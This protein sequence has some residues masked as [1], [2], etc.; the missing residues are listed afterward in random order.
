[1]S[2]P[3]LSQPL[4]S[5]ELAYAENASGSLTGV[6]GTSTAIGTPVDVP[7]CSISVPPSNR[8]VYIEG[9]ISWVQNALGT[10]R[11]QLLIVET[12]G[13]ATTIDS[14]GRVLPNST[15]TR[16]N[17]DNNYV[18]ARIGPTT[19]TR[20]FKLQARVDSVNTTVPSINVINSN[21]A[22]GKSYILAEAK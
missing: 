5:T 4:I 19:Q 16:G 15:S 20:T 18:R 3:N 6:A 2:A 22:G 7:N 14:W 1:V 10:G 11:V 8:P 21:L 17:T 9:A 13:A 12:T